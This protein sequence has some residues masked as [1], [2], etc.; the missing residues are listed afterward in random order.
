MQTRRHNVAID[1][2]GTRSSGDD[3]LSGTI[4]TRDRTSGVSEVW[5][6]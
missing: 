4:P 3:A 5:H 2:Q 1:Q 6:S